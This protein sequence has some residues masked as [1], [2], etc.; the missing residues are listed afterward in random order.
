MAARPRGKPAGRTQ[1]QWEVAQLVIEG[2][3]KVVLRHRRA[4]LDNSPGRDLPEGRIALK[5]RSR[6]APAHV[7]SAYWRAFQA[8]ASKWTRS[9]RAREILTTVAKLG[10]PLGDRAL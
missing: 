4:H 1:R 10:L 9:P 6:T 5:T 3:S 8:M 7:S 2:M